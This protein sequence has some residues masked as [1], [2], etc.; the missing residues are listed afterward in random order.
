MAKTKKTDLISE[1]SLTRTVAEA[2]TRFFNQSSLELYDST[3]Y[4]NSLVLLYQLAT[5]FQNKWA[6]LHKQL[7]GPG[8]LKRGS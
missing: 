2:E 6:L 5:R 3:R 1:E 7:V 8:N 4:I